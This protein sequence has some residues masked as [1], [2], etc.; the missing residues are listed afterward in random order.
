LPYR[1]PDVVAELLT[2]FGD[3]HGELNSQLRYVNEIV[4]WNLDPYVVLNIKEHLKAV[5]ITLPPE[6][7]TTKRSSISVRKAANTLQEAV[8]R[9]AERGKREL[10]N[11]NRLE[12]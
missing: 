3:S 11:T 8:M 9:V 4:Q 1:Y 7:R 10:R 6:L 2:Q 5:K 12:K